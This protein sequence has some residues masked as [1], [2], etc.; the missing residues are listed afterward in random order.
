MTDACYKPQNATWSINSLKVYRKQ[1][2]NGNITDTS[3][4]VSTKGRAFG[5][6]ALLAAS[7]VAGILLTI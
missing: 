6:V 3:A 2:L 7:V 5:R 1:L 4:A